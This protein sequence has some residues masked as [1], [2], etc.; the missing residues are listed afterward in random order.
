M[1]P[2]NLQRATVRAMMAEREGTSCS[3]EIGVLESGWIEIEVGWVLAK[4]WS[5][6]AACLAT[7]FQQPRQDQTHR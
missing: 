5:R 4:L 6:I 2:T 1:V 3:G 7:A